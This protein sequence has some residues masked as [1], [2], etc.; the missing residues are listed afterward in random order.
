VADSYRKILLCNGTNSSLEPTV[1]WLVY[2]IYLD[3]VAVM[4]LNW[5]P[6]YYQNMQSE[7]RPPR[8]RTMR[9][10]SYCAD[11]PSDLLAR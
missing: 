2:L 7:P 5:H 9:E 8:R 11:S 3:L 10:R 1:D 6:C 4:C